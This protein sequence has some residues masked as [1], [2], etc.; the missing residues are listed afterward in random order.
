MIRAAAS[1]VLCFLVLQGVLFAQNTPAVQKLP[2]VA[3]ARLWNKIHLFSN[4]H[5]WLGGGQVYFDYPVGW[6]VSGGESQVTDCPQ[7]FWN[8]NWEKCGILWRIKKRVPGKSPLSFDFSISLGPRT[9]TGIRILWQQY[10]SKPLT[11]R[12]DLKGYTDKDQYEEGPN[13][14]V[15]AIIK[16]PERYTRHKKYGPYYIVC[17]A[18][19]SPTYSE[20]QKQA[21]RQAALALFQSAAIRLAAR[22]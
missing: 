5:D 20:E 15:W 16:I 21:V 13:S 7:E 6:E 11:L 3:H 9:R 22:R 8:W 19:Y 4:P 17:D 14:N 2:P 12:G 10:G 18:D 1:M